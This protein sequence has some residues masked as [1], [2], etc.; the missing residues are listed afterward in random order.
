VFAGVVLCILAACSDDL[1]SAEST[2]PALSSAIAGASIP[3][4]PFVLDADVSIRFI[5]A[6]SWA[7]SSSDGRRF[8]RSPRP[9]LLYHMRA[10]DSAEHVRIEYS[11]QLSAPTAPIGAIDPWR[12]AHTIAFDSN[13]DVPEMHLRDGRIVPILAVSLG[14]MFG[15]GGDAHAPSARRNSSADRIAA[16]RRTIAT[17]ATT[18]PAEQVERASGVI[19]RDSAPRARTEE[20]TTTPSGVRVLVSRSRTAPSAEP[21]TAAHITLTVSNASVSG[22]P[23]TP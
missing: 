17:F 16:L 22:R 10:V 20:W 9:A 1:A 8:E 12:T 15:A 23:R 14:A 5:R 13:R 21:R 4:Q 18:V 6:E 3:D 2:R 7:P 11:A 19:Y